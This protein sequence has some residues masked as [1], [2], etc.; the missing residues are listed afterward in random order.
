MDIM[1]PS[2]GCG[3]GSIPVAG[4]IHLCKAVQV[5]RPFLCAARL[6]GFCASQGVL[7]RPMESRIFGGLL[8]WSGAPPI[9]PVAGPFSDPVSV[10][11]AGFS[12]LEDYGRRESLRLT[13]GR[14]VCNEVR[15]PQWWPSEAVIITGF[16]N[17]CSNGLRTAPKRQIRPVN[18]TGGDDGR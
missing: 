8:G 11:E 3:T 15:A 12:L 14:M 9:I 6:S 1:Q 17:G 10:F 18:R 16:K 5:G 13:A 4:T 7:M 2:E